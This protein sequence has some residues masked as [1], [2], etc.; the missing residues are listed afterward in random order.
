MGELAGDEIG[1]PAA[2]A[3]ADHTDLLAGM[4]LRTQ[5]VDRAGHIAEHLLVGDAAAVADLLDHRLVGAI[6]DPE[7]EAGCYRGITVMSEFARDFAGPFI[8][9]RH[10]VDH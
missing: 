9:A 8:P 6:A 3:E 5:K 2:G 4:R 1:L 10:M 7:I